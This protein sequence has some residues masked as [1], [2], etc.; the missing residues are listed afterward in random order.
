VAEAGKKIKVVDD[1]TSRK[2][3]LLNNKMIERLPDIDITYKNGNKVEYFNP[4]KSLVSESEED[5]IPLLQLH[6]TDNS[7]MSLNR[8]YTDATIGPEGERRAKLDEYRQALSSFG[9][10][11]A[12]I[13]CWKDL[14]DIENDFIRMGLPWNEQELLHSM[15][16]GVYQRIYG[17]PQKILDIAYEP[18]PD[19][20][21]VSTETNHV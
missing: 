14:R 21:S 8:I 20:V 2:F 10:N 4:R 11:Y 12:F 6:N 9:H 7:L 3:L 5:F 1:Y 19:H 16:I 13:M 18:E 17:K 15:A